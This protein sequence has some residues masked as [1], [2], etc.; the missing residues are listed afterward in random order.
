[1]LSR[2]HHAFVDNGSRRQTGHIKHSALVNPALRALADPFANDQEFSF[3]SIRVW[4]VFAA[5]NEDLTNNR[6]RLERRRT[7][8]ARIGRH[9]A[10]TENSLAL[11]SGYLLEQRFAFTTTF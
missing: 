11:L 7:N 3:E 1:M 5:S 10:P 6:L 2:C 9:S 8:A 4:R